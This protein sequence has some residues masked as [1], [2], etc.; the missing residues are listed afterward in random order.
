MGRRATGTVEPRTSSIR[1]KFT[2]KDKRYVETLD[3]APTAP[4]LKAARRLLDQI[5]GEIAAGTFSYARHF[6]D[7]AEAKTPSAYS[8]FG[9]YADHWLTTLTVDHGTRK[10]YEAAIRNVWKPALGEKALVDIRTSDLKVVVARRNEEVS[11]KTINNELIPLRS[12]L[13]SAV[14]DRLIADSPAQRIKNLKHQ[15]PPPDPFTPDEMEAIL[16]DLHE[17]APKAV[18]AYF[19]FAFCTGLRPSEQIIVKWGKVDWTA[20]VLR[21]DTA[22]TYSREKGTKTSTIRDVD[23]TPR[24]VA[25]LETMKPITFMKGLDHPI[26][27]N[28]ATGLPWAT[29]EYQRT[30]YFIPTLKRLGIRHRGAVQTRHTYATI[31]LMGGVNPAYIARQ[32][33]HKNTAMLFQVYSRW[34]DM[35]DKGREAEKLGRLHSPASGTIPGT[36]ERN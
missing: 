3:L 31:A 13:E 27:S 6:P 16:A 14:E 8:T 33:G 2:W 32:M 36:I 18:W 10:H 22:K 30:T 28:P 24:A 29:D 35:A 21:I 12:I 5:T 20:K 25:A 19:E 1:L 7:S 34:I 9:S 15:K 23:L 4:N 11:G 17:R 26:F